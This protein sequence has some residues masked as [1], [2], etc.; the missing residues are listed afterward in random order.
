MSAGQKRN[1][2]RRKKCM[3]D[4]YALIKSTIAF[5]NRNGG[6]HYESAKIE[7]VARRQALAIETACWDPRTSNITDELYQTLMVEKTRQFALTLIWQNLPQDNARQVLQHLR[8]MSQLPNQVRMP[9][10]ESI[11]PLP[12]PKIEWLPC[13]VLANSVFDSFRFEQQEAFDEPLGFDL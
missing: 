3:N 13:D 10:P 1:Y 7:R 11:P 8:P 12:L 2:I 6:P 4:S 9:H 5:I